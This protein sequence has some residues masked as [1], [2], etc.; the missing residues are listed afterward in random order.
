MTPERDARSQ[1]LVSAPGSSAP[2]VAV[3]GSGVA[4]AST[5]FALARAG[6]Q[7]DIIDAELPGAATPAGAGIIMPWATRSEGAFYE[8]YAA[9]AEYY[10]KLLA[11]LCAAGVDGVDYRVTGGLIVHDDAE[12]LRTTAARIGARITGSAIAGR[13]EHV[14]AGDAAALFPPLRPGLGGLHLSGAA[15][16]DGRSLRAGLLAG[17]VAHGAE[18][19]AAA[20]RL[21]PGAGASDRPRVEAGGRL[22]EPDAV[23]VAAGAWSDAVLAPLG[24]STG[25]VAQRGQ[26]LHLRADGM[27][28]GGWPSVHPLSDVYMVAFGDSRL[29]FG[30]TRED[31]SGIDPRVTAAGQRMLYDGVLALAPGL[32]AASVIETR[33]GIR[34]VA[35]GGMPTVRAV[36]PGLWVN[37][38]FGPA[39][40][41]M[42]PLLG[43]RL[44]AE[45]L[46]ALG[47]AP[48]PPQPAAPTP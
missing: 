31:G 48:T 19:V 23:V 45:V 39:G 32:A 37:A 30:A 2:R 38:G 42:G 3:I 33:V 1:P 28:T 43:S 20:A 25:V 15:R 11:D 10:P 17:A 47:A 44:A 46:A 12:I 41:T 36:A 26:I 8:L 13:L 9:G 5:A 34:P 40:L 4:G 14:D 24:V 27:D 35:A 21:I 16:V 29:V 22:L 7:V 6:A 18:P